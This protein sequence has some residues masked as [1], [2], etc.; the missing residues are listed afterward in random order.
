VHFQTSGVH[1]IAQRA[2]GVQPVHRPFHH[3][4]KFAAYGI[5]RHCVEAS[6]LVVSLGAEDAGILIRLDD[7]SVPAALLQLPGTAAGF[8]WSARQC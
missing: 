1:P 6:S 5:L 7:W 4:I 8:W 3:D 2:G